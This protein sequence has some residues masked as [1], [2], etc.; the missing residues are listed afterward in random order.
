MAVY[1]ATPLVRY[2]SLDSPAPSIPAYTAQK[3]DSSQDI[4]SPL[5]AV[6]RSLN[7]TAATV[8][9]Y[10]HKLPGSPILVR[11]IRSSY[12]VSVPVA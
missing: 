12:Q 5:L 2:A 6:L 3:M 1:T 8:E 11:Y 10:F 7:R 4:A 9:H